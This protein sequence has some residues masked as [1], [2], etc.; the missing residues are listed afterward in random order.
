MA[1]LLEG[2]DYTTGQVVAR[3]ITGQDGR[4]KVQ[5][6]L[7][8]GVLQ[9]ELDGRPDGQHPEGRESI[10]EYYIA[11][12]EAFENKQTE[13]IA[14]KLDSEDCSK[15]HAEAVQYYHRYLALFH[16]GDWPR[17]IRDTQRNINLFDFVDEHAEH[18]MLSWSFQQF[19]AYVIMLRTRA[20]AQSHLDQGHATAAVAMLNDGLDEIRAFFKQHRREDLIPQCQEIRFLEQWR[21]EL[22]RAIPT[23]KLDIPMPEPLTE[24]LRF[25]KALAEAI[26]REDYEAAA[27]LRDSIRQLKTSGPA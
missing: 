13:E 6:R 19:R 18:P 15:L 1:P 26:E 5:L 16:L 8:L 11:Q 10:L 7:D 24:R 27:A 22:L 4:E 23:T 14:F 25:E 21:E 20:Q 17:V 12:A 2:W 3:K 9:M